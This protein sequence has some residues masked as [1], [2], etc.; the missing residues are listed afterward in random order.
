VLRIFCLPG[1]GITGMDFCSCSARRVP[2]M[3]QTE[4]GE[5]V[6]LTRSRHIRKKLL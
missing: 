1:Q 2:Q 6:E 3:R 4:R 5:N